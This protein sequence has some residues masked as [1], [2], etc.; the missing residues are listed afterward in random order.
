MPKAILKS[1]YAPDVEI[2]GF[3]LAIVPHPIVSPMHIETLMRVFRGACEQGNMPLANDTF[4]TLRAA[5]N[6]YALHHFT[7]VA[8][9]MKAA[10]VMLDN[11]PS[12]ES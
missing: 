1:P 11:P 2:P 5:I 12:E 9:H 3:P 8:D 10:I 4:V 7:A 6:E